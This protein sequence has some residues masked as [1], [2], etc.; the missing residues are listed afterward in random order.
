MYTISP[1]AA[2]CIKEPSNKIGMNTRNHQNQNQNQTPRF[3]DKCSWHIE[4]INLR[5][6]QGKDYLPQAKIFRAVDCLQR[7]KEKVR[8]VE[9]MAGIK[10]WINL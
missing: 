1:T 7:I 9:I 10:S 5:V 4:S 3:T 6:F 8:I 2:L